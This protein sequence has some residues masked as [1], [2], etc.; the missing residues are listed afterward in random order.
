L[1]YTLGNV[2]RKKEE[3]KGSTSTSV[4]SNM[5]RFNWRFKNPPSTPT[6]DRAG[7]SSSG[8]EG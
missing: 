3:K 6:P 5:S 8:N 1:L 7:G 2:I 4:L